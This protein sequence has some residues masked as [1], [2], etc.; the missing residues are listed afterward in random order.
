MFYKFLVSEIMDYNINFIIFD[1][2]SNTSHDL[3]LDLIQIDDKHIEG[4]E[5]KE[6]KNVVSLS[7]L[8]NN[9]ITTDIGK[10]KYNYKLNNIPHLIP[11][12]LNIKDKNTKLNSK[13][14]NIMEGIRFNDIDDKIQKMFSW[15]IHS[16]ICQSSNG[17]YYSLVFN[18]DD[19]L[20]FS[21]KSIPSVSI[22]NRKDIN[23]VKKIMSEVS[24]VFY[25]LQ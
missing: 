7:T 20:C 16:M 12:H 21:D 13:Y 6:N 5:M 9:W 19:L 17:D 8:F 2:S 1:T 14:V 10:N 23:I 24:M 11:I 22:I 25:K 4:S 18:N 3:K 15:D